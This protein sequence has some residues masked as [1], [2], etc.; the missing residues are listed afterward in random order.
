MSCIGLTHNTSILLKLYYINVYCSV[1]LKEPIEKY[2]SAIYKESDLHMLIEIIVND[3]I[4][5]RSNHIIIQ[6]G[7]FFVWWHVEF[8]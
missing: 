6:C 7:I 1:E 2:L 3:G 8:F 4:N 5:F